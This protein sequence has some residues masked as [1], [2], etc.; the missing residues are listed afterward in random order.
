MAEITWREAVE[1]VEPHVV[2]IDTPRGSGTGFLCAYTEDNKICG[3]ATAAHVINQSHL[4]EEPI[5]IYHFISGKTKL[6]HTSDRVIFLDMKLDTAVILFKKGKIPFPKNTL[7]FIP[8]KKII[9]VGVEIGWVGFPSVSPNN[10]CFFTGINSCWLNDSRTY[11]VD[12]VAINGVSGGPVFYITTKGITLIGSVS[13]YLPNRV[14]ATP[15]L[16]M[17]SHVEQFQS[18]IKTIKDLDEAKKKETPPSE[19]K[20]E[21]QGKNNKT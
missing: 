5:R 3:I 8:E 21:K 20:A 19:L 6:L 18:V 7:T 1:I 17:I 12:G 9:K 4:W 13:A 11:L 16:A 15:G 14:G 10:L 2:K